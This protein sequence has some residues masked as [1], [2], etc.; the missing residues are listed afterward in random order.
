MASQGNEADLPVGILGCPEEA[1]SAMACCRKKGTGDSSPGRGMLAYIL[2]EVA[3]SP[4]I[5]P[6]DF[7]SGLPQ[8]KQ[9]IERVHSSTCQQTIGLKIY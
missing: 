4:T 6:V 2:L 5:K 7:M 8:A 3:F 9:L 1:W